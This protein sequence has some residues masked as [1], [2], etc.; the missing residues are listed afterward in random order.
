MR[1]LYRI[2][3]IIFISVS[4]LFSQEKFSP[5]EIPILLSGTFGEFRKTHFHTGIDIKT[6]GKEGLRVR[7]IDDGDLIRVKVSTSGYGKVVYIRHYDGTTSVYAHLKKFSPRIQQIIKRL[8]YEKKRFE[9]EKFFKKG[10][11]K[12]K[13][14]EIIGFSGNTGGSS[15]PHLHFELRDTEKEKPLN[16]LK[17][18]YVVADTIAPRI[19]NLYLYNFLKERTSNKIKIELIKN[20]NLYTNNDTIKINGMFGFGYSGY[21][22]Q[23]SSYNKNGIYKRELTINGKRFYSYKFDDLIFPDGKKIDLLIDYEAYNIDKIRIKKLFQTTDSKFSFL[24]SND[25]HGLFKVIKDSLYNIKIIFEDINKNKSIVSLVVKGAENEKSYNFSENEIED[26][27]YYTDMEYERKFK[28]LNLI[29]PKDAFYESTNL[30]F[31]YK[32]DTLIIEKFTKAPKK[33]LNL[34]FFLPKNLDSVYLRQTCIGKLNINKKGKKDKIK[35]VFG[36]QKDN[37]I[38]AKSI[39]GGKYFLTK[40][41]ISPSI[42]PINFRNEKWVTN[43]STLRIKV[44]DEFSGI[45]K[46]RASINGKWILM[47]HEPKRKLLFFEFDDLKF[48]KTELKL[49][50]NV[51]DMVGNVNEFEATIYRKKIK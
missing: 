26:K 7:A 40:D 36:N 33:G 39:S 22:R 25:N 4:N 34:E 9:I 51:E 20:K 17:Y 28:E 48:S 3:L 30:N 42:K 11:F 27:L 50:L 44:D 37:L 35:Y 14:S 21:D 12:L 1:L 29:I 38:Y 41:T 32:L 19:H 49:N 15:G 23:N 2:I 16:P 46:Y 5:V 45:K 10:E 8:Q 18:G 47:E 13:K 6:Q 43:L 31:K 24:E